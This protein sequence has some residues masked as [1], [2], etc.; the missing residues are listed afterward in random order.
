MIPKLLT[1]VNPLKHFILPGCLLL[2][3]FSFAQSNTFP[4][5][6]KAGIETTNPLAKLHIAMAATDTVSA[7]RIG[8]PGDAKPDAGKRKRKRWHR[9]N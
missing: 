5:S 6:G 3:H 9:Y 7:I 8:K 2:T 4:T 1:M